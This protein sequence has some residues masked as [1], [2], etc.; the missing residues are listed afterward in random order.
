[1]TFLTNI[2]LFILMFIMNLPNEIKLNLSESIK[3]KILKGLCFNFVNNKKI[4]KDCYL[5][6]VLLTR[7]IYLKFMVEY[8]TKKK[9]LNI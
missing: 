5:I 9:I 1:M 8:S 4:P 2:K 3:L 7:F 6:C